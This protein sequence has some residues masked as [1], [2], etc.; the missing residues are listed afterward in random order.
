MT[1]KAPKC[2]LCGEK[3]YAT[4]GHIPVCKEHHEAYDEEGRKRLPFHERAV[5]Q[6]I[7]MAASAGDKRA[8]RDYYVRLVDKMSI[9]TPPGD[10]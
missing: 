4:A 2:I 6:R 7:L 1:H 9:D 3:A 8:S 5:Y 10:S